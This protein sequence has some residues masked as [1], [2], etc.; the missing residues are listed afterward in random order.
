MTALFYIAV[1]FGLCSLIAL[2]GDKLEQRAER[3]RREARRARRRAAAWSA[4]EENLE[5]QRNLHDSR[6]PW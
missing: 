1:I 5:Q 4:L 3:L 2:A 6:R